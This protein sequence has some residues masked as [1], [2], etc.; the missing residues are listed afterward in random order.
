MNFIFLSLFVGTALFSNG[1]WI[2]P[3]AFWIAPFFMQRYLRKQ[4]LFVGSVTAFLADYAVTTVCWWGLIPVEGALYFL[5]TFAIAA[6]SLWLPFLLDRLLYGK[7][8]GFHSTLVLPIIFTLIEYTTAM[9][10]PYGA[11]GCVGATQTPHM[12][13]SQIA[14]VT[15]RWGITFLVMWFPSTINWII[16]NFLDLRRCVQGSVLFGSILLCVLVY[17]NIRLY[18]VG[19]GASTVRASGISPSGVEKRFDDPD[20]WR[21]Y[22]RVLERAPL[23]SEVVSEVKDLENRIAEELFASTKREA[24][25]GSK[26]IAWAESSLLLFEEDEKR[27]LEECRGLSSSQNIH[28]LTGVMVVR[29]GTDEPFENMAY[30][31]T[32][33]GSV[34]S[35]T[36]TMIGIGD[37]QRHG[38]G[39]V[40]REPTEYGVLGAILC[41][42]QSYPSYVRKLRGADLVMIPHDD[43]RAIDPYFTSFAGLYSIEYGFNILIPAIQG[44]SAAFDFKGR[45]ISKADYFTSSPPTIVVAQIPV[46]GDATPYSVLGDWFVYCCLAGAAVLGVAGI[47]EKRKRTKDA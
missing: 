11:W 25:A 46:S 20:F 6:T 9:L 26:I 16:D 38:T 2:A 31:F 22:D 24:A 40:L 36:K 37:E 44:L 43:W 10:S 8:A 1:R 12:A 33:D 3:L 4:R 5:I 35:Y 27:F 45:L 32:P 23:S 42:D 7:L 34:D 29:Q 18:I 19:D 28:L 13:L 47:V 14:S 21:F 39:E 30:L 41:N 15:G 17:G